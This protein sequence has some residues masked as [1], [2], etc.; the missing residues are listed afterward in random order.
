MK[1]VFLTIAAMTLMMS[2]ASATTSNTSSATPIVENVMATMD[3]WDDILNEYEKF[4][5]QYVEYTKKA[6]N[7]DVT[8]L[9]KLPGLLKKA[10]SLSAK[11]EKASS[12]MTPAQMARYTKLVKKL[13]DAAQ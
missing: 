11:L 6:K 12:E 2:A 10:Q 4:V 13:A 7:G 9:A 3:E 1:K 8:A 5:N